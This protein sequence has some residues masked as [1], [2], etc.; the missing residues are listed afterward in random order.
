MT[1]SANQPAIARELVANPM[2]NAHFVYYE[3]P[4]WLGAVTR[5]F[6]HF[7]YYLWQFGALTVA[8]RLHQEVNL[9]LTHH[10]TYASFRF[11]ASVSFL[12]LP[13]IWGPIGGAER[14]PLA[15]LREL[16][17]TG[18]IREIAR[19]VHGRLASLDPFTAYTRRKATLLLATTPET[20]A[21]LARNS[22][23]VL[24]FPTIGVEQIPNGPGAAGRRPDQF[25][26]LTAGNLAPF[27]GVQLALKAF[28]LLAD[29]VPSAVF[30]IVGDGPERPRLEQL[31]VR[32]GISDRVTFLGKLPR[33]KVLGLYAAY[34]VF[35]Y[36]GL[37]DS[38]AMVVL[39][40]MAA[41]MPVVCLDL[42]GPGV[43]VTSDCGVKVPASTPEQVVRDLGL[44]LVRLAEDEALRSR[45]GEAGLNRVRAQMDWT[46]KGEQINALYESVIAA[47]SMGT[48]E[49]GSN[50]LE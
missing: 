2:P 1:R 5:R 11:P 41:A 34:D 43:S 16:G 45:M 9:D 32:L 36:A 14:V 4:R 27:K 22:A 33:D 19:S 50:T 8:R 12:G 7:H 39:E 42:G 49:H 38:G 31:A 29:A 6:H 23:H 3:L 26:V 28:K 30:S 15:F 24:V 17:P 44:A 20:R 35:L 40:A 18:A 25:R 21:S 47:S 48:G 10:A 46:R 37:R 13:F